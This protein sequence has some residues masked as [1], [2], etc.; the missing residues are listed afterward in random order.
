MS[1][2]FTTLRI[3]CA[4]SGVSIFLQALL[5][6]Q[7]FFSNDFDSASLLSEEKGSEDVTSILGFFLLAL[8][9]FPFFIPTNA[10]L[11]LDSL[12]IKTFQISILVRSH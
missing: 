6:L 1:I 2:V 3:F 8:F 9:L 4:S 11:D 10:S 7:I 5:G 12:E